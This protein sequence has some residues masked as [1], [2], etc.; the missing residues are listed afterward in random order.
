M[1]SIGVDFTEY[2]IDRD[3]DRRAEMKKKTGGSTGV[4]VIDIDGVIV[5]GYS[6]EAIQSALDRAAAK[7]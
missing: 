4:P 3:S 1:R 5:R 2:N 7:R 6:P